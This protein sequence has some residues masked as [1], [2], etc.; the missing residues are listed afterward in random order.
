MAKPPTYAEL[1]SLLA[2][3]GFQ[4]LSADRFERVFEHSSSATVLMF[5]LV[6]NLTDHSP[7]RPAD[8][9][10]ASVHL[11]GTGFISAPLQSVLQHRLEARRQVP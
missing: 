1:F 8:L 6:G 9:L 7:V 2:D 5:S 4:S 10:S 3:L 11:E